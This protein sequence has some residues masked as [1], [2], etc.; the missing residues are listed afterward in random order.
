MISP[1]TPAEISKGALFTSDKPFYVNQTGGY[2]L[3]FLGF[4]ISQQPGKGLERS[5]GA[6]PHRNISS[7]SAP[8]HLWQS[9]FQIDEDDFMV[10]IAVD[11][12][13]RR[14]CT[15]TSEDELT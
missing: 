11:G 8:L 2:W 3:P 6:L 10:V 5:Y 1:T 9:W 13:A 7:H 12:E 14:I 4:E 15:R